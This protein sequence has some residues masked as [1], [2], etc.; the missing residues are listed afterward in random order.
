[1]SR[2]FMKSFPALSAGF[3]VETEL[4]VHAL[5]LRV[6]VAEVA[7]DYRERPTGSQSKLRTIH[8]G[9]RIMRTIGI[10]V[11]EERPL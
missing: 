8:D 7:T 4:T 3:E 6:P 11:K 1:M 5:L 9:I 10:L 2:R